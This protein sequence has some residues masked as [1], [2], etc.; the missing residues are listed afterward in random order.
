MEIPALDIHTQCRTLDEA[1]DMARDA[2]AAALGAPSDAIAVELVIAQAAPLLRGVWEARS[3]RAAAVDAE[4]RSLTEAARTLVEEWRVS[5]GDVCRLLGMSQQ[6]VARLVP[7]RT[8]GASRQRQLDASPP[9]SAPARTNRIGGESAQQ[10]TG[11][12]RPGPGPGNRSLDSVGPIRP[13]RHR[14]P[15]RTRPSWAT[16]ED[17]AAAP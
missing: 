7:L 13:K 12:Q 3:R 8:S 16:A 10:L 17:D 6:E 9:T 5:Q 4:E 14:P 2:I 1:E 11:Q 15:S